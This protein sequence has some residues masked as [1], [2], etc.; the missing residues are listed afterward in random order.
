MGKQYRMGMPGRIGYE[1]RTELHPVST[2]SWY[3]RMVMLWEKSK[4]IGVGLTCIVGVVGVLL[5]GHSAAAEWKY[6]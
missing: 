5:G 2:L 1:I 6:D 3:W 4:E